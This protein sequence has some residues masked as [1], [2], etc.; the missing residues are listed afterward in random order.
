MKSKS[1]A[2]PEMLGCVLPPVTPV[3]SVLRQIVL[4]KGSRERANSSGDSGHPCRVP[5]VTGKGFERNL[6]A[7]TCADGCEYILEIHWSNMFPQAYM[8]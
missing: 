7:L 4:R 1:S 3:M 2:Y 6:L 8:A 5:F